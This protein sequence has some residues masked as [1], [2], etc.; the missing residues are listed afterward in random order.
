MFFKRVKVRQHKGANKINVPLRQTASLS[1]AVAMSR[2]CSSTRRQLPECG[3]KLLKR[4][5]NDNSYIL[6]SACSFNTIHT[7]TLTYKIQRK[8]IKKSYNTFKFYFPF[9][10]IPFLFL[11]NRSDRR[12][13]WCRYPHRRLYRIAHHWRHLSSHSSTTTNL[14]PIGHGHHIFI[15]II[16]WKAVALISFV[17]SIFSYSLYISF[18]SSRFDVFPILIRFLV[19]AAAFHI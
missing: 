9:P 13:I 15:I 14:S 7:H 5:V 16:I 6:S 1:I 18:L 17:I 12:P 10:I 8:D 19:V 2:Q 3:F 4:R 11:L